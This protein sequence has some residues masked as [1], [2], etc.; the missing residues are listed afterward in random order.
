[1]KK[2]RVEYHRVWVK[3]V[4]AESRAEAKRIVEEAMSEEPDAEDGSYSIVKKPYGGDRDDGG[5]EGH[6]GVWGA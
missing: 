3:T 5:E 2:Y 4:E 1:M 6:N